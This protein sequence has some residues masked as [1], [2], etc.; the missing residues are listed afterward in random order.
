[1]APQRPILIGLY[2]CPGENTQETLRERLLRYIVHPGTS[3]EIK[4][5]F[6][7]RSALI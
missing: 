7:L 4:M 2:D 1:M 5:I 3:Q 6:R